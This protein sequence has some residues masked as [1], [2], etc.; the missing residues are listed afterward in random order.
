MKL[1]DVLEESFFSKALV[2]NNG[3]AR[4]MMLAV[5]L[6]SSAIT[7]VITAVELY[8]DYRGDLHGIKERIESIR[9]VYLPTLV[10]S[11]WVLDVASR[12]IIWSLVK[13]VRVGLVPLFH[14]LHRRTALER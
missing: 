3:I 5:I 10:E 8:L 6:F 4:R 1:S 9:K 2:R 7:A 14:R 12:T 13:Q 11:V